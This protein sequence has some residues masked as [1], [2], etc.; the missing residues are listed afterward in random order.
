M[1]SMAT[2]SLLVHFNKGYL[3]FG[4]ILIG[5][6]LGAGSEVLQALLLAPPLGGGVD[7]EYRFATIVCQQR[8]NL[9]GE[10]RAGIRG[11]RNLRAAERK[12]SPRTVAERVDGMDRQYCSQ[13]C[14]GGR[15]ISKQ[16]AANQMYRTHT[17]SRAS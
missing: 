3:L 4:K 12:K 13:Q 17:V 7:V 1:V 11:G 15:C 14:T 8:G 2:D 16:H 5:E 6:V 9:L 10:P